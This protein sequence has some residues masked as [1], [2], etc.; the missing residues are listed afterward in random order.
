MEGVMPQTK[1]L[2]ILRHAKS[3]W[4]DPG[5]DD[6]ERPLAPRGLRA[7]KVMAE[8]L[9][10]NAIEPELVLCSSARRTRETLEGVAPGGEHVIESELYAATTTDLVDRLRRLPDDVGSVMLIGHNPAVQMLALRLARRDDRAAERTAL[11]G[12]FPT[13]ALATLTF[14]CGWS[15]LGPGTA[16]LAAFLTPKEL[17][18]KSAAGAGAPERRA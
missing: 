4:D 1:R 9:R 2:F 13:G 16:R 15:E 10:A 18:G 5:L 3:S 14:E 17:N 6:H 7:C 11:E 12:K 8:H